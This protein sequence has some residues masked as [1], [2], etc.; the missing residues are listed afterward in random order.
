MSVIV[1]ATSRPKPEKRAEVIAALEAAIV[2]VHA[3]DDGC[4]LYALNETSDRLVMIEKWRDQAALDA[5]SRGAALAE[6]QGGLN[7]RLTEP[8]EVVVLTPHPAGTA[9]Q[10][11]V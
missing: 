7:G 4:E 1:V 2:R 8:T 5:H 11:A 9:R 3:E 10:G 6:L